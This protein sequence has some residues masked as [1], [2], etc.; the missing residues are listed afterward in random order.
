MSVRRW[1][2]LSNTKAL[3]G[4]FWIGYG[5][6]VIVDAVGAARRWA[7]DEY[8]PTGLFTDIA[9]AFVGQAG[10]VVLQALAGLAF[11]AAGARDIIVANKLVRPGD[12]RS[13][14]GSDSKE[15]GRAAGR[16]ARVTARAARRA[17]TAADPYVRPRW[18]VRGSSGT[19]VYSGS[20]AHASA[21]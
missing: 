19:L 15:S 21:W 17:R 4:V 1:N 16:S 2:R 6:Y 20:V 13:V 18:S 10:A 9:Q 3:A 12:E 11:V 5:V 14:P 7:V 8:L